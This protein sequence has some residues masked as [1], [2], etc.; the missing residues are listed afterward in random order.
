M[1][2]REVL[3]HAIVAHVDPSTAS[4]LSDACARAA[5][6][7]QSQLLTFYTQ[8][9]RKV[10]SAALG[11]SGD[12]LGPEW[13]TV[14]VERWTAD[15]VARVLLLL[16]RAESS[17]DADTFAA[18]CTTCYET[19]DAR[20]QASW[21]RTVALLPDAGRYLRVVVDACRTN[22]LPIF[23]ATACENLFPAR[24]FPERNFN[25]MVLKAMFNNVALARIIGLEERRNVELGRMAADYAAERRAAGR[26]VPADIGLAMD[27]G[28]A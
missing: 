13:S 18:D 12:S 15:D 20:E 5:T 7:T 2:I 26:T 17:A 19:G 27:R 24:F 21:L 28:Q 16:T 25:Q 3:S 9:P 10:G 23:E 14:P 8:V 11:L 1:S 4:W 22:I 6:G